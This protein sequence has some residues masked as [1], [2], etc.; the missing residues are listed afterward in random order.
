MKPLHAALA[1]LTL[2]A[3]GTPEGEAAELEAAANAGIGRCQIE[4]PATQ[5]DFGA[6]VYDITQAKVASSTQRNGR[7]AVLLSCTTDGPAGTQMTL[8]LPNLPDSIPAVG[9][10]SIRIPAL[11]P[12]TSAT[13]A[14]AAARY[15]ASRP[16]EYHGVSGSVK[17][18]EVAPGSL[19][20]IYY[21]AL[22][23]AAAGDTLS[24]LVLGGAFATPRNL[25]EPAAK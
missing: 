24:K 9:T 11:E 8:I 10:Y 25:I 22:S 4:Q 20:G 6:S 16:T 21:V 14:W 3:C 19:V 17:I 12:D 1:L 23:A 7:Y 5:P 18:T 15:P 2:A 13:I